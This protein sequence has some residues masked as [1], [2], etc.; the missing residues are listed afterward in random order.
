MIPE[1]QKIWLHNDEVRGIS[2]M[3]SKN[4]PF[5]DESLGDVLPGFIL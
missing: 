4:M 1:D 5:Q 3:S 2:L